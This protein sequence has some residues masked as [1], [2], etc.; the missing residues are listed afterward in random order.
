MAKHFVPD[1]L[2][3]E[4]TSTMEVVP[5]FGMSLLLASLISC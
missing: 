2:K 4:Q 1:C 3:A 5:F